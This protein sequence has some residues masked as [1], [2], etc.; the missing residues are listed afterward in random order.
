M[1]FNIEDNRCVSSDIF[2]NVHTSNSIVSAAVKR[3]T[4]T[5]WFR[6]LYTSIALAVE[7]QIY[8]ESEVNPPGK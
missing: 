5:Q 6:G 4:V 8:T 1:L 7:M 2:S 3:V